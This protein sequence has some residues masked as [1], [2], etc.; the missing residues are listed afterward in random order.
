VV[1]GQARIVD[2]SSLIVPIEALARGQE[3]E[4]LFDGL[5]LLLG[6]YRDTLDFDRRVPLD[7]L[8]LTDLAHKV[9]GVGSVRTRAWIALL[10][11]RDGREPLLL[12]LTEPEASVLEEFVGLERV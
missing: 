1:D 10:L 11:G 7:Q 2:Q 9:V 4:R 3:R 8:Q 5:R 6:A 12:Q